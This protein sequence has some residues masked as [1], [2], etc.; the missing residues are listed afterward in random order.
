MAMEEGLDT[1]PVLLERK[2]TIGL[3]DNAHA[4]GERLSRMTANLMVQA[5]PLIEATLRSG[6]GL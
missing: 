4:L 3:Q 5:L 1:G 2:L 6:S